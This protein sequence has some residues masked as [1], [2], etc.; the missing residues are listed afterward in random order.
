MKNKGPVKIGGELGDE[1]SPGEGW[2][3]F[4]RILAGYYNS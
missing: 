2:K 3:L 1:P 4:D